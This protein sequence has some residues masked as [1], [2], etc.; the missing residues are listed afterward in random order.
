MRSLPSL[1]IDWRAR[2]RLGLSF[3]FLLAALMP[4]PGE[5][6]IKVDRYDPA[7]LPEFRLWVTLLDETRPQKAEVIKGFTV[8]VNGEKLDDDADFETS[9]EFGAPMLIGVVADARQKSSWDFELQA[10]QEI[11]SHLPPKSEAFGIATHDGMA[12]IPE[13]ESG[14]FPV[15]DRPETLSTSFQD[16]ETGG[17]T[18]YFY[19]AIKASLQSFP[20][21]KTLEPEADDGPQPPARGPK[22]NPV[23][24]DRILIVMGNG[25]ME[26]IGEGK[27]PPDQLW[28][29]VRMARRRGVR[30]MTI[31][32][33]EDEGQSL[34]TLRVLARKSGGTFRQAA[35]EDNIFAAA[36]ETSAE[37]AGRF[38]LT[39]ESDQI[40]PGDPVAFSVTAVTTLGENEESRDFECNVEH[41]MGFFARV[42]DWISDKWE[43]AP[44]WLRALIVTIIL[45]IIAIITLVIMLRRIKH[46][47]D[48]ALAAEAA[49]I[50]ALN[51]RRPCPICGQ[52][53]M[54]D[55]QACFF[56]AAPKAAA[57]RFR[58]T[59][60]AG[61]WAGQALRFD[62]DLVTFGSAQHVDVCVPERR[63]APEH[64]GLRDR[65]TEF[66]LSDFNTELGTFVN[67]ERIAQVSLNE[68]DVIRVGDTE[69]VFGIETE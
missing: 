28:D 4:T 68:G 17:T 47:R 1:P 38:V 57:A 52:L 12:R 44:F 34:W 2:S 8:Y 22:Q 54:P 26:T 65:G 45:V 6:R 67:G 21:L 37:L 35:D 27:T 9:V 58:L 42:G 14:Q 15:T 19:R 18:P 41:R 59:G 30:V 62:K 61:A 36:Q 63:V 20:V 31:G 43:R 32:V 60:R 51:M 66:I 23:P 13:D 39:A 53:M 55:W 16:T 11:F 56:C 3:L 29:L 33:T 24:D 48:A 50:E 5:A 69:L 7:T 25:E 46:A 64:C 10:I 40:R 49:R